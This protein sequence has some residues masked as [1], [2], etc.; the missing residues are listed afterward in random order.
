MAR[1]RRFHLPDAIVHVCHRCNHGEALLADPKIKELFLEVLQEAAARFDYEVLYFSVQDT[2]PHLLL[3]TPPEIEGHTL[4]AFMHWLDMVF[5]HRLNALRGWQGT[6]WQGPYVATGWLSRRRLWV[7]ELLLWYLA[8]NPARRKVNAVNAAD[9]RWGS[10][11]WLVRGSAGPV[12]TTLGEWLARIYGPRGRADP[13]AAFRELSEQVARPNWLARVRELARRGL[14]W[15]GEAAERSARPAA[16]AVAA[17]AGRLN[18]R[19]WLREVEAYSRLLQP[20][21]GW[22]G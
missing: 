1:R 6:T 3:R 12:R 5:G 22:Q 13:V 18:L 15:L 21:C 19:S 8:T 16:R 9:Y 11:Y 7:L 10:L 20:V 14:P 2:H 17:E 4:S